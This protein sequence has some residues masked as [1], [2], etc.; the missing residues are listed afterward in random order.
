MHRA[1]HEIVNS[2]SLTSGIASCWRWRTS[3]RHAC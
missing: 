3:C 1:N 2:E